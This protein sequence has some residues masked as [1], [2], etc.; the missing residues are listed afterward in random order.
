VKHA[1]ALVSHVFSIHH[2]GWHMKADTAA[3]LHLCCRY[4]PVEV[5]LLGR[6]AQARRRLLVGSSVATQMGV[7]AWKQQTSEVTP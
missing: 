5:E 3:V 2:S 6:M 7:M 4:G 1:D